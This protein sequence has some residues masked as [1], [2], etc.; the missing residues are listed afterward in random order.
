MQKYGRTYHLPGSP[1][2]TSD[3]KRMESTSV[4][5]AAGDLVATEKMDGENTTIHAGGTHA[6]SPDSRYH[7]SRDW[8]KAFAA[9]I[10]PHLAPGER[11][12][13]EYLFARHAIPYTALPSYFL[14]FAWITHGRVR[15]WDETADR[16]ADLGITPVP[17]LFRGPWRPGLVDDLTTALDL[18]RQEGLVLRTA[19]EF[20]EPAMPQ[21]M[22]KWVR[23]DHVTSE[24]HWMHAEII[25]NGLA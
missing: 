24:T 18:E 22:G 13:G 9:G 15:T 12:V 21:H 23:S 19:S 3:D 20:P 5:E 11:I 17:L 10:S 1:G 25:R 14:G 16:F 6:R 8:M 2:A 7:P 4:L